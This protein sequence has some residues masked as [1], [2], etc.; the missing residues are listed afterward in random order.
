MRARSP[1]RLLLGL[2]LFLLAPGCGRQP[3]VTI[4]DD[5]MAPTLRKGEVAVYDPAAYRVNTP[6]QKDIVVFEEK[7]ELRVLRAIGLQFQKLAIEDGTVK[8]ND[9]PLPEPYLDEASKTDFGEITVPEGRVFLL[10]DNRGK[11]LDSRDSSPIPLTRLRGKVLS[12]LD[13]ETGK[14]E[15]VS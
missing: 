13:P 5:A 12:R 1:V 8:I 2:L 9:E 10:G 4:P 3:Q 6:E 15:P 14:G 11:S 7:G